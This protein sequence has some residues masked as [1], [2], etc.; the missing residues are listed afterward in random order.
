[1][2]N[3]QNPSAGGGGSGLTIG[4][5]TV[6]G[7]TSGYVLTDNAGVLGNIPAGGGVG[8][9]ILTGNVNY[10]VATTGSDSNTGTIG[11]PWA[12]LQ[13]AMFFIAQN[14][15][16]AG[17]LVTVNI[18]SGSFVGF[19]TAPT[20]GGGAIQFSGAGSTLTTITDGPNDATYNF[21]EPFNVWLAPGCLIALDKVN[22]KAGNGLYACIV[23]TFVNWQL[24]TIE[25]SAVDIA[26]DCVNTPLALIGNLNAAVLQINIGTVTVNANGAGCNNVIDNEELGLVI[27]DSRQW[28]MVGNPIITQSWYFGANGAAYF[29]AISVPTGAATGVRFILNNNASAVIQGFAGDPAG[30]YFPGN[31]VGTLDNGSTYNGITDFVGPVAGLPTAN[32]AST[33]AFV[34]DATAA[35]FGAAP[36]G[37]GALFVPVYNTGLAW[38]MG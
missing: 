28:V 29:S 11:A 5:T 26:F 10:Y 37:G 31:V 24:G 22:F 7:G 4:S 17:F 15:D 30:T 27:D 20:T 18:G 21:G 9:T 12:T 8:R 38:H 25:T 36:V 19:G 32:I 6:A 13:H 33:S 14:L 2:S 23:E 1:M 16:T 35:T 3:I 34:T